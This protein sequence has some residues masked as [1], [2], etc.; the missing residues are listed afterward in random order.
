MD[1][2]YILG[3]L[4]VIYFSVII[5]LL[6]IADSDIFTF[7]YSKYG[8]QADQFKGKVIWI[9]GASSGIGEAIAKEFAVAG[10]RIVLSAR[11]KE[12]LER[13]KHQCLSIST[14]TDNDILVIPL[15][16]TDLK[17]HEPSLRTVVKHFGKLD[18]LVSNA[19]Q[20]QVCEFKD[21]ALHVDRHIFEVNVFSLINMNR[22][23][24]NYFLENG[25]GQLAVVSSVVAKF[26]SPLSTTYSASKSAIQGYFNSLRM[27]LYGKNID[28]TIICPGLTETPMLEKGMTN[29]PGE[30]AKISPPK[31]VGRMTA[32][33]VAN[34]SL[35]SMANH[36]SESW[37]AKFPTIPLLYIYQYF[38]LIFDLFMK[39]AGGKVVEQ[40][41]EHQRRSN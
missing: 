3:M 39:L 1:L 23:V 19:A 7:L 32:E 20:T 34:L 21:I 10:A 12:E 38:P 13:V 14:L 22:I 35:I 16:L 26:P 17:S 31:S 28:V 6:V 24:V 40:M 36:L 2:F 29:K 27:E 18:V 30:L 4:V 37:I 33:R 15:D 5:V 41:K 11:R 9:T 25:A 8:K